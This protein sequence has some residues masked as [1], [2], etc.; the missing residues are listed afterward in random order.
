MYS[1]SIL[2]QINSHSIEEYPFECCGSV[3]E[4][5]ASGRQIALRCKNI[6]NELHESDPENYPRDAHNAY[7]ISPEDILKINRMVYE[8]NYKLL[9]IYHSHP[10]NKAYFSEKDYSFAVFDQEPSYPGTDYIIVSI[11]EKR[12]KETV[13]FSWNNIS[14]KFLGE[15]IS[16]TH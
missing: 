8:Q 1:S 10:D 3:L 7:T 6:Q 14:K 5:T 11:V 9:A 13:C 15:K 12:V 2:K 4:D 16:I